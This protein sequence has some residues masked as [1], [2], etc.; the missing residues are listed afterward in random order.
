MSDVLNA[1]NWAFGL[2]LSR[3]E[4]LRLKL[5]N[6]ERNPNGTRR[7]KS[8]TSI[9]AIFTFGDYFQIVH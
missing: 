5:S 4:I 7:D 6:S 2:K 9:S 3:R 8:V 1:S